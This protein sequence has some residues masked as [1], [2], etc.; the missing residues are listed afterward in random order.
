MSCTDTVRGYYSLGLCG[1][2]IW[3]DPTDPDRMM[4]VFVAGNEEDREEDL[5]HR[6]RH[7][8]VNYTK[9]GRAYITVYRRRIHL[10]EVMR[11][12]V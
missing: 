3:P 12:L 10:D 5:A 8:K 9:K 7:Y 6:A 11:F 1:Y 4:A 2:E